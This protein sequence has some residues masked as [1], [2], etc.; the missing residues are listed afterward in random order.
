MTAKE[1]NQCVHEF[2]DRLYRFALKNVQDSDLAQDFVQDA[3]E[4][5][6]LRIDHVDYQ[7]VKSYLFRTIV[8][9][10][11]DRARRQQLQHAH[12]TSLPDPVQSPGPAHDVQVLI[13]EG[14]AKL[15]EIQRMVLTLRDYEGYSY[16]EIAELTNLSTDQV[17]VYIFRA[18]RFLK[19]Y[20]GKM[21]VLL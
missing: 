21:E 8:N 1:Y 3:F 4:R 19:Q 17:K 6:W 20:I 16:Q 5:L 18:R 12:L 9:L 2:A 14:V 11:I 15:T 13:N 10:Q 7:R